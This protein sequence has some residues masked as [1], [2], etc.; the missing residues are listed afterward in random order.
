MENLQNH[1][2]NYKL[3]ER[4]CEDLFEFLLVEYG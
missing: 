2:R 1:I 4:K 3:V